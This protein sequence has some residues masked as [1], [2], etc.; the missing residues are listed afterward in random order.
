[1]ASLATWQR[2]H[3]GVDW[4][5]G[6]RVARRAP[7]A[8]SFSLAWGPAILSCGRIDVS[9]RVSV[10][11]LLEEGDLSVGICLSG[12]PL[13]MPISYHP[14]AMV[15]IKSGLACSLV[16]ASRNAPAY[17]TC[18]ARGSPQALPPQNIFVADGETLT[19]VLTLSIIDGVLSMAWYD[20]E[21]LV[22]RRCV[23]V[24]RKVGVQNPFF[25]GT[26]TRMDLP[27]HFVLNHR[28]RVALTELEFHEFLG[29][30]V[31]AE[32][33][34][35]ATPQEHVSLRLRDYVGESECVP[36]RVWPLLIFGR[37]TRSSPLVR[38]DQRISSAELIG[39]RR[40]GLLGSALAFACSMHRLGVPSEL[41]E[42]IWLLALLP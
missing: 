4:A 8:G 36:R 40:R 39:I 9:I 3:G 17:Y 21:P 6:K 26:E 24:T 1:M 5:E 29:L 10:P 12:P 33:W 11:Y 14:A 7:G 31:G 20:D 27:R 30:E 41:A 32:K 38:D 18:R 35:A 16:P 19:R 23:R 34:L 15:D 22:E 25:D 37:A 2:R 28:M 42:R 13:M